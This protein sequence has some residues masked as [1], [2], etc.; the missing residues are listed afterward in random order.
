MCW[1]E[2]FESIIIITSWRVKTFWKR[3]IN[4]AYKDTR[5]KYISCFFGKLS[6]AF[7]FLPK[8]GRKKKNLPPKRQ[9]IRSWSYFAKYKHK[10][11]C[12]LPPWVHNTNLITSKEIY[13]LSPTRKLTKLPFLVDSITSAGIGI[14][15]V[16][17]LQSLRPWRRYS[18]IS[19]QNHHQDHCWTVFFHLATALF[20]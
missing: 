5:L 7:Q 13:V 10:E 20:E 9:N 4:S 17:S 3:K 14:F 1:M 18:R 8:Y 15:R 12:P 11:D 16:C 19:Y 2:G 6:E